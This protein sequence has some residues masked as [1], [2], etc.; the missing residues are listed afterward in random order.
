MGTH[1][2]FES[3]FDCLTAMSKKSLEKD[4]RKRP[5]E[6]KNRGRGNPAEP[7]SRNRDQ[8][9]RAGKLLRMGRQDKRQGSETERETFCALL[10]FLAK[11]VDGHQFS[12]PFPIPDSRS[13]RFALRRRR[14]HVS[15]GV[16][17]QL[18]LQ[19]AHLTVGSRRSQSLRSYSASAPL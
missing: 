19:T 16:S 3:D 15:H 1:P 6:A 11:I 10:T 4:A 2:I 18:S 17:A 8:S 9:Q 13:G 14:V 7:H 5:Q 12:F